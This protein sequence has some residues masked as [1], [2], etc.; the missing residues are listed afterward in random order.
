MSSGDQKSKFECQQGD[1][2]P[3]EAMPDP[4]L[5]LQRATFS[6]SLT[7]SSL[8]ACLSL[9][10]SISFFKDTSPIGQDQPHDLIW[11]YHLC[12]DLFSK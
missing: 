7:S 1:I 9:Q 2:P 6:L 8:C 11:L 10:L 5:A 12:E 4:I 3:E